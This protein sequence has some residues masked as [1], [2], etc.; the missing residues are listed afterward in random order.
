MA[1]LRYLSNSR[2]GIKGTQINGNMIYTMPGTTVD[3]ST[4]LYEQNAVAQYDVG[5]RLVTPDGR[6]FRYAK[7]GETLSLGMK[8][9]VK[10]GNILVTE[11]ASIVSACAAGATSLTV[12]FNGDFWDTAI[13]ANELRGGY[14]SLYDST[15]TR[16]QRLIISNTAV[17]SSGGAC[18]IGIDGPIGTAV[19]STFNCEVLANPYIKVIQENSGSSSVMGM[20]TILATEDYY[21]WI[22]TWGPFRITPYAAELGTQ[23]GERGMCFD[24]AGGIISWKDLTTKGAAFW[25]YQHAGFIIEKTASGTDGSA[26]PF[27]MVQISP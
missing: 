18:T 20:P 21:F 27:I 11:K 12:T 3:M 23:D 19:T 6:V 1:R 5:T 10:N 4:E 14:I 25:A 15:T 7:A 24:C 22:Q 9:G 26:A 13:D 8:Y 16:N 17:T 2:K